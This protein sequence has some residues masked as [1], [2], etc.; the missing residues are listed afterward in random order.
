MFI[1]KELE[2][3][4]SFIDIFCGPK[5]YRYNLINLSYYLLNLMNSKIKN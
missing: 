2:E 3:G 1:I 4:S 5:E